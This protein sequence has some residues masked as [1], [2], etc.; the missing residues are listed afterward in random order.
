MEPTRDVVLDLLPIYL[1]GEA[2]PDS[3]T[4]VKEHLDRDPDLAR[5]AKQWP[6]RLTDT[7][8]QPV[9]RDAEALAFSKAKQ[10]ITNRII[11]VSAIVVVAT[12]ALAATALFGAM[13]FLRM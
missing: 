12:F 1:A 11:T 10:Q 4:L 3:Q 2:S 7:P 6:D 5:L 9:N 13:L 8:P